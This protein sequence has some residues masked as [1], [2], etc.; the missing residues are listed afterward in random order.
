VS[1]T[2]TSWPFL[3]HGLEHE[4]YFYGSS[5]MPIDPAQLDYSGG[6]QFYNPQIQRGLSES[7]ATGIGGA[8]AG[9]GPSA[10]GGS[11]GGGG[12]GGA[13][14][15]RTGKMGNRIDRQHG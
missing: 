13:G 8:P 9:P 7:G 3:Y 6:G 15:V 1:G 14:G 11:L 10:A 12:G 4:S 2:A 5:V